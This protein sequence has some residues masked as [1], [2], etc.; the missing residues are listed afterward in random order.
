[1]STEKFDT[2]SFYASRHAFVEFIQ[3]SVYEECE[4]NILPYII[5]NFMFSKYRNSYAYQL[6][7]A[8]LWSGERT[9]FAV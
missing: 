3:R 2:I 5:K 8:M 1:M 7:A 9:N 6:T 4:N